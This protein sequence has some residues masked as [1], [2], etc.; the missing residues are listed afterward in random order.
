MPRLKIDEREVEVTDGS[1]ILEA[2]EKLGIEIPTMCFLKGLEPSTSCMVCVVKIEGKANFVPSCATVA[3]DGMVVHSNTEDVR[4]ARKD[5]LELLLSDHLGDCMGPCQVACPAKMNIPLM[6]RQIKAGKLHD[7]LVT[8]K[9]DIALPAVLGR[10]CPAPCEKACRRA[11]FDQAVSICLLKRYVAD[12]DLAGSQPYLPFC[13]PIRHQKVAIVGA[14]PCGLAAAYYL[15]QEGIACTIFDDHEKAGGMMRY[16]VSRQ[17]LPENV[18]DAE[19]AVIERLGVKFQGNTLVGQTISIEKLCKDFDAVF[20]ATG[21]SDNSSFIKGDSSAIAGVFIAP[22]GPKGRKLAIR[23]LA[24]GKEA[25]YTIGNYLSDGVVTSSKKPFNIRIGKVSEDEMAVFLAG[26]NKNPRNEPANNEKGL[27]SRQAVEESAR[28][29]HCDCRKSDS[30]KLRQ[31]AVDYEARISRYKSQRR[32]FIQK[33]EHP[34]I[35]FEPG[36]CIRCGLCVQITA[37]ANEKFGLTFI[38]RGFDMQV[39]IPFERTLPEALVNTAV[40]CAQ[41]CPTG[42]ISLKY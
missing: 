22:V 20:V 38:G 37:A 39:A 42:A 34:D 3:V 36:K 23:A 35:I 6:L 17:A 19:I 27:S 8:V 21:S 10:I 28:C 41:T 9:Q 32:S 14:G 4:Q 11:D 13:K 40:K 18:L 2:A 31:Y 29:L 26:C 33:N 5:A 1:T 12:V 7:A 25:A 15:S 24:D 30:C 16:G